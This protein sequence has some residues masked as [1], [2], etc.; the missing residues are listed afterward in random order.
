MIGAFWLFLSAA[1]A[2]TV[3][4][5]ELR[6]LSRAAEVVVHGQVIRH[7]P[8]WDPSHRFIWTHYVVQVQDRLKGRA[9]DTTVISEPG[10][11]VN[12]MGMK[13]AGVPEYRD[14]EEVVVFLHRTPIG[15][16]RCYGL[17]QGKFSVTGAR[18]EKRVRADLAGIDRIESRDR[19]TRKSRTAGTSLESLNGLTLAEFKRR[20]LREVGRP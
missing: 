8:A 2:T 10:G 14:G 11:I 18:G 13:V 20:I 5:L 15:Y 19:L 1:T 3:P 7:W 9:A 12:G 16:W 4:R 17:M 6:E